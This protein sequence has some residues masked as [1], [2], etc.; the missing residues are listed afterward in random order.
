MNQSHGFIRLAK[1]ASR[2]T[3]RPACF[4]L[5]LLVVAAWAITVRCSVSA[6]PGNW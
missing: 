5:A 2:F 6:I 3:G 1:A 4:G